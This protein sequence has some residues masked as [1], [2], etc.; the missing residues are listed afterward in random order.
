MKVRV[1]GG[2]E[3]YIALEHIGKVAAAAP[4]PAA[5][6]P[7]PAPKPAP[8]APP[9]AAPAAVPAAAP[10]APKP[11]ATATPTAAAPAAPTAPTPAA[12]PAA[13]PAVDSKIPKLAND[14]PEKADAEIRKD[15]G[16]ING[17][18]MKEPYTA[19]SG[20]KYIKT[21][22][23]IFYNSK[24]DKKNTYGKIDQ[25]KIT[26]VLHDEKMQIME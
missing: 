9:T 13:A 8:A 16:S 24:P 26:Y 21:D 2:K 3:G 6:A 20:R 12:A 25:D 19:V 22:D 17:C 5:A 23:G 7:A 15:W 4:A 1:D 14:L 10:A 18:S 11:A